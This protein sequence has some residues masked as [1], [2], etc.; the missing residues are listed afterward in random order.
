MSAV[1]LSA[2]TTR[3]N[4]SSTWYPINGSSTLTTFLE[5]LSE[6]VGGD[7]YFIITTP[8]SLARRYSASIPVAATRILWQYNFTSAPKRFASSSAAEST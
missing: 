5:P 3:S 8:A 4:S 2:I 7:S 6:I 1:A